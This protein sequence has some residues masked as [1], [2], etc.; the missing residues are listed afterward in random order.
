MK[1]L[2]LALALL[3][4][5]AQAAPLGAWFGQGEPDDKT[6]YWL[7]RIGADGSFDLHTRRCVQGRDDD[8]YNRGRWTMDARGKVFTVIFRDGGRDYIYSYTTLSLDGNVWRYRLS[9]TNVAF[10]HIGFTFES[11]R[12][13]PDFAFPECGAK[14]SSYFPST[15]ATRSMLV[16][17]G[18]PSGTPAVITT[19]SPG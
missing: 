1:A 10:G 12:V 5:N 9:G 3:A 6:E 2:V 19:R 14:L 7:G 8:T 16:A 4:A 17:P 11:T 18:V 15:K 13:T